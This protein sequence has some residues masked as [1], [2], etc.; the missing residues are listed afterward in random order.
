MPFIETARGPIWYAEHQKNGAT[1]ILL[2]HGAGVDHLD[3]PAPL[4]RFEGHR[5]IALDLPG[6]GRSGGVARDNIADYSA[7]VVS[8]MDALYIDQAILIGHSMGGAI[9]QHLAYH[10]PKRVAA[11]VLI[12]T[13][14]KLTVNPLI[15]EGIVKDTEKTVDLI[16]K[17]QWA[18]HIDE[19]TRALSKQRLLN[20]APHIIQGDYIAC[21]RFDMSAQLKDIQAPTLVICGSADKMTP[22]RL[23]EILAQNIPNS[24]LITITDGGHM[25]MLEQPTIIAE[26]IRG[27]LEKTRR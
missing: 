22:P 9:T 24:E 12:C 15:I 27:W 6:H 2:I 26:I 20:I 17:W 7:D 18:K 10:N 19:N 8:L 21:N 4:R 13:G 16:V 25:V 14:S 3:W 1:T 5:V 11:M 23:G